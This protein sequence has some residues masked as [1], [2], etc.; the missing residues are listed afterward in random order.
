[1]KS[2]KPWRADQQLQPEKIQVL[3][4]E[5]DTILGVSA[6]RTLGTP[7]LYHMYIEANT[8]HNE[9]SAGV[10]EQQKHSEELHLSLCRPRGSGKRR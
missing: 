6:W 8:K 4:T 9:V 1:M 10:V 2:E 3:L 5:A 7:V